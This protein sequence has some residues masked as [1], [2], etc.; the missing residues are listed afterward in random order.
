MNIFNLNSTLDKSGIS[1]VCPKC[2]KKSFSK[3]VYKCNNEVV[4]DKYGYCKRGWYCQYHLIPSYNFFE[5]D[6]EVFKKDL[7]GVNGYDL[8]EFGFNNFHEGPEVFTHTIPEQVLLDSMY[9]CGN[10]NFAKFLIRYLEHNALSLLNEYYVGLSSADDLGANIFW[11]IDDNFIV[12]NGEVAY[13]SSDYGCKYN[14][15]N[16]DVVYDPKTRFYTLFNCFF[17]AHLINLNPQKDIAIVEDEKTA[18]VASYFWPEFNWLATGEIGRL[19]WREY[20][21]YNVLKGK[22]I[23]FYTDYKT[24][25]LESSSIDEEVWNEMKNYIE[26]E[27]NCKIEVKSLFR[28]KINTLD[29]SN[30]DLI[31][32]LLKM[33]KFQ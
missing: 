6:A 28:D 31:F 13:Y 11:R 32:Q 8:S 25:I 12:R 5:N 26:N 9:G 2:G 29:E 21:V 17:G 10:S 22:N 1:N 24:P 33:P 27:I 18:I 23:T 3:Y 15:K 4:G 14:T 20:A 7:Y 19:H 30:E 16:I